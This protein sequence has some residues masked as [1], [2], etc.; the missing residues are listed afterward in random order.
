M[1]HSPVILVIAL[2]LSSACSACATLPMSTNQQDACRRVNAAT[3]TERVGDFC[4][5]VM[6]IADCVGTRPADRAKILERCKAEEKVLDLVELE[7]ERHE[8]F[9]SSPCT[10]AGNTQ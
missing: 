4:G 8:S 10:D 2:A 3:L 7:S 5:Y 6:A 1:R 9:Q